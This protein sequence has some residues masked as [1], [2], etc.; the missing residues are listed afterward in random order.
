MSDSNISSVSSNASN[1]SEKSET[2]EV[3]KTKAILFSFHGVLSPTNWE[4]ECILPY[5]KANLANYL[6]ENW[7]KDNITEIVNNL[8]QESFDEH[9]VLENQDSPVISDED[10]NDSE[11]VYLKKTVNDFIWLLDHKKDNNESL[12][13]E[14]LVWIEGYDRG[15]I[16]TPVFKDVLPSLKSL[17]E[18]GFKTAI[19]S[20][21][22]SELC[23]K[24]FANT[25]EG[26]LTP[27]F[28]KFYDTNTGDKKDGESYRKIAQDLNVSESD[29]LFITNF[30]QEAK[31]SHE[32]GVQCLLIIRS[33][34]RKIREYYLIKFSSITSLK[35]FKFI[36]N[37]Q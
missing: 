12:R 9:F 32:K 21:V 15:N 25:T 27:Y 18:K 20:S 6:Q 3:H 23:H 19:F 29:V 34:N 13:L 36:E 7:N 11:D 16:K 31:I 4:E 14:K 33:G 1:E 2:T 8:R 5:I 22:D 35:Q 28:D 17:K 30:G 37:L 10:P 26:D 24:L